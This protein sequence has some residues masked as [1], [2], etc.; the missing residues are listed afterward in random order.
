[1]THTFQ[2]AIGATIIGARDCG[3]RHQPHIWQAGQPSQNACRPLIT[4]LAINAKGFSV[5]PPPHA[6]VF[7][8]HNHVRPGP[9]SHQRR[10]QPRRARPNDQQITKRICLFIAAGVMTAQQ[11]A[12]A[13]RPT[14]KWLIE[15]FP[16]GTR[17]HEGFIVKSCPQEWCKSIIDRQNIPA[18]RWPTVLAFSGK[19]VIKF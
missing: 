5:K 3:A 19:P 16:K 10:H 11:F 15:T 2:R 12:Q 8:G 1:M 6:R 17:P 7:I 9:A 14:N 18:Q 13:R 4:R